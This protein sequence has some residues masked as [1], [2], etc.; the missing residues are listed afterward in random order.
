MRRTA[1]GHV[2]TTSA[3]PRQG[4]WRTS[5]A[6]AGAA[7]RT[8][9][10]AS[11]A[12][13]PP[14]RTQRGLEAGGAGGAGAAARLWAAGAR[15]GLQR[16]PGTRGSR[17]R[18]RCG[19]GLLEGGGGRGARVK[20]EEPR[21]GAGGNKVL[22]SRRG[23][24]GFDEGPLVLP[25]MREDIRL[26]RRMFVGYKVVTMRQGSAVQRRVMTQRYYR[27]CFPLER[28]LPVHCLLP[29]SVC[30]GPQGAQEDRAAEGVAA[31]QAAAEGRC[32]RGARRGQGRRRRWPGRRERGERGRPGWWHGGAGW[33]E[34][35]R[36]RRRRRRSGRERR[37]GWDEALSAGAGGGLGRA[38]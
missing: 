20:R 33:R 9:S 12:T 23:G 31:A 26:G 27:N 34:Q 7:W 8:A 15:R 35:G 10:T 11:T 25:T 29:V 17:R 6:A 28:C 19:V 36:P 1:S 37:P 18:T 13:R 2:P 24:R 30:A 22:N 21:W 4:T 32:R 14:R 5:G 16:A 3:S 38:G